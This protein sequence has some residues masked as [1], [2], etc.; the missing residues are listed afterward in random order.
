MRKFQIRVLP[1]GRGEGCPASSRG[2]AFLR[3]RVTGHPFWNLP[4]GLEPRPFLESRG[5]RLCLLPLPGVERPRPPPP[6]SD[7][8]CS[9]LG[10][11]DRVS[12]RPSVSA[13]GVA[14]RA[15]SR[16]FLPPMQI[17]LRKQQHSLGSGIY[18]NAGEH[19]PFLPPSYRPPVSHQPLGSATWGPEDGARCRPWSAEPLPS[20]QTPLPPES[21]FPWIGS[22]LCPPL[23]LRLLTGSCAPRVGCGHCAL[24]GAPR[25]SVCLRGLPPWGPCCFRSLVALRPSS[26]HLRDEA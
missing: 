12:T 7:V 26:Y 16:R 14:A 20:G 8:P 13:L 9:A 15:V 4:V 11:V 5:L 3:R 19:P 24:G 22:S 25:G 21:P 2:L 23:C 10:H 18:L 1:P 17:Y 6:P